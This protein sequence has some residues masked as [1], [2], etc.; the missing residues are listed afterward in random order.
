MFSYTAEKKQISKKEGIDPLDWLHSQPLYPKVFWKEKHDDTIR[1]AV[2]AT[3]FFSK[4]PTLPKSID[5]DVRFYGGMC[6][7]SEKKHPSV[8]QGFP[9]VCFW[10]PQIEMSYSGEKILIQSYDSNAEIFPKAPPLLKSKPSCGARVDYPLFSDWEKLVNTTLRAIHLKQLHKLVLA[11]Q[12]TVPLSHSLSPWSLLSDL[13]QAKGQSTLFAFQMSPSVC[14]LGA[15]PELLFKREGLFVTTESIAGTRKKGSTPEEEKQLEEQL[16]C[17]EKDLREFGFVKQ[18]LETLLLPLAKKGG[19]EGV[20]RV[21][22]TAH[23]QHLYNK[24]CIELNNPL[25]DGELITLLHPTPAL[26]G[27]PRKAALEFLKELEPFDRGWY[28]APIG[29]ISSETSAF[30]VAIRSALL[31]EKEIHLFAGLGVVE[32]SCPKAEWEELNAKISW[33]HMLLG[34]ESARLEALKIAK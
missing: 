14:F 19:W 20:D 2:G 9:K 4:V 30:Y 1:V 15:T 12:T 31:K 22:K 3:R 25:S 24:L 13:I 34:A 16:L 5:P 32:G 17:S 29:V 28:G 23:L 27:H 33:F 21:I 11:R 18:A 7:S 10:L 8:W 26:G 6:F